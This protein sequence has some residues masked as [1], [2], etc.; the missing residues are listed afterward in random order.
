[1][2]CLLARAHTENAGISIPRSHRQ[3][4]LLHEYGFVCDCRRCFL[5][6]LV[7][8]D[9]DG[10]HPG[11]D[12]DGGEEEKAV[13]DAATEMRREAGRKGKEVVSQGG[14][15]GKGREKAE[16]EEEEGWGGS[17]DDEEAGLDEETELQLDKLELFKAKYGCPNDD[18]GG[19]LAPPAVHAHLSAP[20]VGMQADE[21]ALVMECN[22]CCAMTVGMD[23]VVRK[24]G[25]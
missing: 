18:C 11:G 25:I 7:P 10:H 20:I 9:D 17:D 12:D 22:R 5:E 23:H 8:E 16:E 15:S 21:D 1:M 14:A 19:T 13:Q 6:G 2:A 4:R 3:K 24:F